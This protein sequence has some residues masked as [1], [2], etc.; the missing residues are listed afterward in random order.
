MFGVANRPLRSVALYGAIERV[1][2]LRNKAS[3]HCCSS[4]VM[5]CGFL[6]GVCSADV[7]DVIPNHCAI[8]IV[9]TVLKH[10]LSHAKRLH[11]PEG[12]GMRNV[13]EHEPCNGKGTQV[14]QATW[15]WKVLKFTSVGK[16]RQGDDRLEVAG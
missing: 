11:D 14:L 7:S 15:P 4:Q 2:L 8:K 5:R 12:L 9:R 1:A 3:F 16:E 6:V 10:Q 13:V